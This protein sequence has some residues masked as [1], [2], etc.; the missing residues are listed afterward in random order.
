LIRRTDEDLLL[1]HDLATREKQRNHH[2]RQKNSPIPA[3]KRTN[4][5]CEPLANW[6]GMPI[7]IWA[8]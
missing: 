3:G 7:T 2:E 8:I 6:I 1:W 4:R 5:F